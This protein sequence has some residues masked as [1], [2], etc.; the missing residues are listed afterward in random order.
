MY[1]CY[2]G[3]VFV[4]LFMASPL[5]NQDVAALEQ[6]YQEETY[7]LI[8]H[9]WKS[10]NFFLDLQINGTFEGTIKGKEFFGN[11]EVLKEH[12][13]LHLSND[14]IEED[15]FDFQYKLSNVSFN[16]LDLIDAAG[17]TESLQLTD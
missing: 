14:P 13:V 15:E 8:A 5:F 4:I 11:W 6:S 7:L 10:D 2:L 9:K 17:K 1:K 12:T 3:V 16:Q